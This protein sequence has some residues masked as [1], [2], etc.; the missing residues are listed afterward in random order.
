MNGTPMRN[1]TIVG[2][3]F[4][5][6]VVIVSTLGTDAVAQENKKLAQTG[7]KFLSVGVSARQAALADAFTAVE[8]TANSMFYNPSAMAQ[9]GRFADVALGQ[10]TWIADIKHY[11][12]A[13][14]VSPW[15]GDY[16]TIGFTYHYVD[17]GEV[18]ATILAKNAQGFLDVG[19]IKP[20]GYAFG[21]GYA[22]ALSDRF[23]VGGN[24]KMVNQNL[25]SGIVE[26][27][28]TQ[29]TS[30]N[31]SLLA[32][33][34]EVSNTL[35]VLAFD[36]GVMYRTG[37]KSLNFGMSVRNFS[38]E[39]TYIKE[40]FQLPLTFR[41]GV[42]MNLLDFLEIDPESQSLLLA[43]DAEHPRDYP[44]Q[45]KVG[46]E[47]VFAKTV[48]LRLGLV[49]PADEHTFSYGLGLQQKLAGVDFSLDYAY[50]PFG[51]FSSGGIESQGLP[52]VSR[53]SFRFGF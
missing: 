14:A 47:Y 26:A 6:S 8:G 51:I 50:T 31:D 29:G 5:A 40:G 18:Q 12:G 27:T 30:G 25:G 16:G 43:V 49:S 37:F 52:T 53:L 44:E 10:I 3:A 48:A 7:L 45:I 9:L 33:T 15:D 24:V 20:S 38:R 11:Y 1:R 34:R 41:I 2:I 46:L 19:T 28:I 13:V 36:F 32:G 35:D 4:L 42:A 21:I 17:Y 23:S 22:K 39:V